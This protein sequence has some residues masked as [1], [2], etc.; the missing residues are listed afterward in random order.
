MR[1]SLNNIEFIENYILRK[2][3]PS[4]HEIARRRIE[5]SPALTE[6]FETQKDIIQAAK[7]KG[8][9]SEIQSIMNIGGQS[10]FYR[11][12]FWLFGGL[13]VLGVLPFLAFYNSE[14]S[15][16]KQ[17]K[18]DLIQEQLAKNNQDIVPWIPFDIQF[19]DLIAEKGGTMVGKDG[20]LII[21]GENSLLDA[22]GNLISGKVQAELIEALDWEDMIAY[23][24]TTT[25]GG[26]AL[27]SGGMIRIRYKQN[28]KEV[29]VDPGKPM[30]IE[31]PTDDYNP[32]MKVWE[33]EVQGDL[34]DWKNPQKIERYL[35]K[36]DLE[37]LDFI[38]TGFDSEV[39]ALLPY[40]NHSQLSNQ[41]VDSLYYSISS[42]RDMY[43]DSKENTKSF[44]NDCYFNIPVREDKRTGHPSN[45]TKPLLKGKNSITGQ[46][47]D[48]TGK[49][50]AGMNINLRMDRYLEHDEIIKT[51]ENG[52]F[53]FDKLYPGE[54]AIYASLHS[55]DDDELLWKYCLETSFVCPKKPQNYTLDKPLV[56]EY[57]SMLNFE[58][59]SV[60]P[61]IGGCFIDPLS[62]KTIKGNRF[63]N[64][65]IATKEFETRLQAMHLSK[66]GSTIL[67]TYMN[68][69]SEPLWKCDQ[70]ASEQ[71]SG[72]EQDVF[73]A[74]AK[75]GLTS[76]KNDGIHQEALTAYYREQRIIYRTEN[77]KRLQEGHTKSSQELR[78]LRQSLETVLDKPAKLA[79]M[80]AASNGRSNTAFKTNR[81]RS[82]KSARVA[83]GPSYKFSWFSSSWVNIDCYLLQ[84]GYS[85]WIT[86]ITTNQNPKKVSVFQCIRQSKTVLGLNELSG[87]YE[88]R[89]PRKGNQEETFSLAMMTKDN[90]LLFDSRSYNPSDVRALELNLT[91]ISQEEFYLKLCTLAPSESAIAKRLKTEQSDLQSQENI[92][93][94]HAPYLKELNTAKNQISKEVVIYNRL[95]DVIN[96]C[97][98]DSFDYPI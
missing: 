48:P 35:S 3:D 17:E 20:T 72:T 1:P 63:Q 2:F 42:N 75:Q 76:V 74:F 62:I 9:R 34:L 47:V 64:T 12:R 79:A 10:F 44:S 41:L 21:L 77:R 52:M 43:A 83:R 56:A 30:H 82:N 8:L 16:I 92:K 26:K 98:K 18:Y 32:E 61:K 36:V 14:N 86:S 95:F 27:S 38:P 55:S 97:S 66:K 23:N 80:Q 60:L 89:F 28:G 69:L 57:T 78:S 96:R 40:R 85:P 25:S 13:V 58:Q 37:Y 84:L 31:I 70:M 71:L 39:S 87:S 7:R 4:E 67:Q 81:V 59:L 94:K 33:G 24:L 73:E 5:S 11:H 51:D 50:I 15:V 91:P 22:L 90:Q 88:A 65:F 53:T 29:F 46:I 68:N 93:K 45:Q 19:F 6:L 54:V 49:P